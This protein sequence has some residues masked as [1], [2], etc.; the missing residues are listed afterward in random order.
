MKVF[1]ALLLL[2]GAHPARAQIL[3]NDAAACASHEGPAILVTI[4]GLKDRKGTLK[5]E[6]YP[7]NEQDFLKPDIDLI[8]AKKVFRRIQAT[9]PASGS[10]Q[11]CIR[12]PRPGRY[13]LFASHDRDGRDKFNFF[14]DGAGFPSNS[15][16]GMSRP[17]VQAA[18]IDV[19]AGITGATVH[20]QYLHGLSGFSPLKN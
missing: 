5:V 9:P 2:A 14:S 15:R 6:L 8:A 19:G 7:G 4:D 12:V 3:G 20:M 16:L 11:I 18:L 1:V 17:K 10:A 13:A